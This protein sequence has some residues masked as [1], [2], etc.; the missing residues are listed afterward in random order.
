MTA[1][2]KPVGLAQRML[3]KGSITQQDYNTWQRLARDG[4]IAGMAGNPKI[5]HYDR[6]YVDG[7]VVDSD[8]AMQR[9]QVVNKII[10]RC[11]LLG[12]VV[13]DYV[14]I[15]GESLKEV[16]N[17]LTVL[18]EKQVSGILISS[19]CIAAEVYRELN[20]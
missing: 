12:G 3:E 1:I 16:S 6:S 11:G 18:N 17:R 9:R 2:K 13:I 14:C 10:G 20:N 19:L 7:G 4:Y 5:T 8:Y 15:K